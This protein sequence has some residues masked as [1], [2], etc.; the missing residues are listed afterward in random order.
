MADAI[1]YYRTV[2]TLSN[3]TNATTPAALATNFSAPCLSFTFS[4]NILETLQFNYVNNVID[5]PVPIADG[6]R[7]INKQENGLKSIQLI[8]NG[9]FKKPSAQD[10][11]DGD[12]TKLINMSKTA[13]VD[14]SHIFG[15]VGIYAPSSP[16][17]SLDPN[18]TSS[19]AGNPTSGTI[20]P[21]TKGYTISSWDLGYMSPKV[22]TYDFR[23]VL[24]FG[25]TWA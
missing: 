23:V 9:R 4:D 14:T 7:K 12:I 15:V 17:F 16:E 19:N 20:T 2:N 8:I 11:L 25:G 24:S 18:A 22:R 13:Q 1:L 10:S 3:T 21:A 5:I 6:T